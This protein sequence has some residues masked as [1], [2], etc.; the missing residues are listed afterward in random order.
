MKLGLSPENGNLT[1]LLTGSSQWSKL[2]RTVSG[3]GKTYKKIKRKQ[4]TVFQDAW[5][6]VHISWGMT[7]CRLLNIYQRFKGL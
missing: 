3:T 7:P 5:L 4:R 2:T 6:N 1:Q